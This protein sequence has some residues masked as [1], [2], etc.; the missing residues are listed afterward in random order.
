MPVMGVIIDGIFHKYIDENDIDIYN[1]WRI[2]FPEAYDAYISDLIEFTKVEGLLEKDLQY[3][4]YHKETES[5]RIYLLP[6][7]K[8][9][10]EMIIEFYCDIMKLT[11]FDFQML[12]TQF[13]SDRRIE[14]VNLLIKMRTQHKPSIGNKLLEMAEIKRIRTQDELDNERLT[15]IVDA[16]VRYRKS[17]MAVPTEWIQEYNTIIERIKNN[18]K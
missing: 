5:E 13:R 18:P 12:F 11:W 6:S 17:E 16:I 1:D 4:F 9:I 2:R 7:E 10:E 14:K 15:E 8:S 3:K